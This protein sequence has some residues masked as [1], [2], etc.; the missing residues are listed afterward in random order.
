MMIFIAMLALKP[1]ANSAAFVFTEFRNST[2]WSSDGVAWCLGM[3]TSCY[4]LAGRHY[5]PSGKHLATNS[6]SQ[7]MMPR[8]TCRRK[9]LI[10]H[11]IFPAL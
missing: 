11:A 4:I 3:L 5:D 2:G 1:E 6:L 7:A 10:Q 9:S 8:L